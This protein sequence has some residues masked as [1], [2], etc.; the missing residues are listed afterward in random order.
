MFPPAVKE[1]W[2]PPGG[3]DGGR[4]DIESEDSPAPEVTEP[5]MVRA[6][7]KLGAKN[8]APGPDSVPGRAWILAIEAFGERLR[9]LFTECL[10]QGKFPE[11]WKVAKLVLLRKADRPEDAPSA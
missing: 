4:R 7:K 1:G 5:E 3:I 8:T 2:S 6:I 9:G 10:R 11:M